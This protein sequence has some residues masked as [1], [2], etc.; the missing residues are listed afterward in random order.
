MKKSILTLLLLVSVSLVF[1][2]EKPKVEPVKQDTIISVEMNINQFRG[3]MYSIDLNIDSK[4]SSKEILE[5]LQKAAKIVQQPADK[6]KP[7]TEK[8]D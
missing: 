8:K 5:F 7:A 2:Q 1:A 3:L 4:K 6:P